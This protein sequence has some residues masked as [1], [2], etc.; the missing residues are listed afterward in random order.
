LTDSATTL[1]LT[2]T[3]E[4][5]TILLIHDKATLSRSSTRPKCLNRHSLELPSLPL[6]LQLLLFLLDLEL[7]ISELL[8]ELHLSFMDHLG[9]RSVIRLSHFCFASQVIIQQRHVLMI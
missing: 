2:Y 6:L 5:T 3:P 8:L 9:E 7:D 4:P 1:H